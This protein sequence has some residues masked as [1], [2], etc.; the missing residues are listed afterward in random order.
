MDRTIVVSSEADREAFASLAGEA[1]HDP[2]LDGDEHLLALHGEKPLARCS[3]WWRATPALEQHKVGYIGHFATRTA[4]PV[5]TAARELFDL[6]CR[7]L[8]EHGCTLA[9]GPMDGSTWQRYRLVTER[10][11]DPPFFLEPDNPD[12]WP[13]YFRDAGFVPLA[14]Y[15]SARDLDLSR[16]DPRTDALAQRMRSLDVH[17]RQLDAARFVEEVDRMYEVS[18]ASFASAFLYSPIDRAQCLAQYAPLERFIRPELVLIAEQAGMPV[19]FIFAIPDWLQAQRGTTI[20]TAIVKTIA[21]LPDE[22][23]SGLGA[24]LLSL[25]RKRIVDLGYSSAIHALMHDANVGSRRLSDRFGKTMRGYTLFARS[26]APA[27]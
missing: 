8:T 6:A 20:D 26:L 3:L 15:T 14:H 2:H 23:Y 4:A 1:K 18:L 10:G 16:L 11:I 9:V 12:E 21:I 5:A 7:R 13:G 17:I 25:C 27:T 24:L 22:Q 19:G